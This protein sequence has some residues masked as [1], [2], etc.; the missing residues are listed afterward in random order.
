[1]KICCISSVEEAQ[2]AIKYGA[3]E[4]GLLSEIPSDP[5]VIGEELITEIVKTVPPPLATFLLTYKTSAEEIIVQQK[6]QKLIQFNLL[7]L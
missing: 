5:G 4:L 6:K 2:L 3:S 7:I 1:M